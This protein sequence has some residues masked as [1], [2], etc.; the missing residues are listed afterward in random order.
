MHSFIIDRGKVHLLPLLV[1]VGARKAQTQV[2][3][4]GG[5][6]KQKSTNWHPIE[7]NSHVYD[8]AT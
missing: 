6:G 7:Y 4:G 5:E 8:K 1:F 2:V 3:K